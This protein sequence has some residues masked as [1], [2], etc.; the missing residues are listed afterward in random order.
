MSCPITLN[1]TVAWFNKTGKV[2]KFP[3]C[4]LRGERQDLQGDAI[5][6]EIPHVP[7]STVEEG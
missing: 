4:V 1:K 2:E 7:P 6:I 5:R 3:Y